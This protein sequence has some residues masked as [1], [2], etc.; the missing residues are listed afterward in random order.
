MGFAYDLQNN[1]NEIITQNLNWS[2]YY[3]LLI[4]LYSYLVVNMRVELCYLLVKILEK[5]LLQHSLY[6]SLVCHNI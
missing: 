3:A 6:K 4:M 5:T 2:F 1:T